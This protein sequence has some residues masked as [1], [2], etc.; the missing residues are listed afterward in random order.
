M[1]LTDLPIWDTMRQSAE[2]HRGVGDQLGLTESNPPE[3]PTTPQP[4]CGHAPVVGPA[5]WS[6]L[7]EA[8]DNRHATI[9]RTGAPPADCAPTGTKGSV[10]G[11]ADTNRETAQ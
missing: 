11:L 5:I 10:L 3:R 9:V 4:L 1:Y 8:T 2:E 7:V 6:L